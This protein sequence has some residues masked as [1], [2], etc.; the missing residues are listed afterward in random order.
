MD[1]PIDLY[2]ERTGTEFWS[3][4][5]NA[6]TNLAFLVAA[7]LL[8]RVWLAAYRGRTAAGW[9]RLLLVI[10][11]AAIGLG[12]GLFHTFA[13]TWAAMADV[14]PIALFI[15]V[16]LLVSL[17]RL[18][19]LGWP[20]TLAWFAAYHG[21]NVL[22]QRHLDPALLNGSVFYLPSFA[23]LALLA[24]WLAWRG[25]VRSRRFTGAAVLFLV[26]L[27]F[28]SADMA[29]CAAWPLGTHF[30]WHLLNATLLW[31]LVCAVMDNP[32]PAQSA[33]NG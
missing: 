5:V 33:R 27:G 30:L 17:K 12:S 4:P 15:S 31:L 29:V 19:G 14:L 6:L 7:G 18:A 1:N 3:E 26:S 32:G 21:A 2:C 22:A 13:R 24:A 11:V 8:L 23:A 20:A 16:F 28:R 10:L 9:D 25:H